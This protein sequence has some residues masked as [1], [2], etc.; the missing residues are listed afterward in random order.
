MSDQASIHHLIKV[1]GVVKLRTDIIFLSDI[2]LCNSRGVSNSIKLEN[3]L[4]TNPYCSYRFLAQS[5]SNKRGVGIL[6]K[7]KLNLTVLQEERDPEDNFLALHVSS[8][9]KE[10]IIGSIYGP[11]MHCPNFF[12]K[13]Y[14]SLTRLGNLPI[15]LGGDWN[16]TFSALPIP[17]VPS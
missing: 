15:I 11:N 1:Y 13:L 4:L 5:S 17:D 14:T 7:Q 8:G 2:R 9:G 10:F 6:I 16:C 3:S 12:D